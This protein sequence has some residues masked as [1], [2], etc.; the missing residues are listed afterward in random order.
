MKVRC[1]HIRSPTQKNATT[2]DF[3]GECLLGVAKY[4]FG[5]I[6]ERLRVHINVFWAFG[7]VFGGI[8]CIFWSKLPWGPEERLR[9]H[10][11]VY[12]PL[13]TFLGA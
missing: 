9:V 11:N 5:A 3:I 12:G 6:K 2:R 13:K 8:T 10:R 4:I 7:N 1:R